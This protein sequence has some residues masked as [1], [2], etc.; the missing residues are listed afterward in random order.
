MRTGKGRGSGKDEDK[1]RIKRGKGVYKEELELKTRTKGL[2]LRVLV[3]KSYRPP[4]GAIEYI[5]YSLQYV[6]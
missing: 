2:Y 1:E 6:Q 4:G 5:Q 3:G